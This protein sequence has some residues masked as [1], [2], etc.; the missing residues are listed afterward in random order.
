MKYCEEVAQVSS[1]AEWRIETLCVAVVMFLCCLH[2]CSCL[3]ALFSFASLLQGQRNTNS[4]GTEPCACSKFGPGPEASLK[5]MVTIRILV[6]CSIFPQSTYLICYKGLSINML[7]NG[8]IFLIFKIWTIWNVRFV[9][10]LLLTTSCELYYDDVTV[11]S[12]IDI[13]YSGCHLSLI[14]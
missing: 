10:N 3:L 9:W 1:C 14:C 7:Q 2:L 5:R 13:K 4:W 11:T 8:A 6:F 12:F